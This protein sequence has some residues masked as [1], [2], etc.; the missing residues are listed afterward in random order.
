LANVIDVVGGEI[1]GI[2]KS[3]Y[4]KL[5]LDF[6]IN[7]K[8]PFYVVDADKTTPNVGL[9]Y[10]KAE[11]TTFLSTGAMGGD[12]YAPAGEE[13]KTPTELQMQRII[14]GD[15]ADRQYDMDH[16][17]DLA[18]L[19]RVVI[20]LPS[21]SWE[22]VSK[23]IDL[24]DLGGTTNTEYPVIYWFVSNGTDESIA[25]LEKSIQLLKVPHILVKN[26]GNGFE[27][28]WVRQESSQ[29]YKDKIG[30]LSLL[31]TA[32]FGAI[33]LRLT[34]RDEFRSLNQ[35]FCDLKDTLKTPSKRRLEGFL[36]DAFQSIEATGQVS[37]LPPSI[38]PPK[39]AGTKVEG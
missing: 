15:T 5:L 29:K 20:A 33:P 8:T 19:K 31:G 3:T 10:A 7:A 27:D 17:F 1:G 2:G 21:Q 14:L 26:R 24:N 32:E 38:N 22:Q 30:Q 18:D 28:N 39:K 11:Y 35:R 16:I 23:W 36:Q 13:G 4:S 34:Q 25:L 9:S 37:K 12:S 6:Y